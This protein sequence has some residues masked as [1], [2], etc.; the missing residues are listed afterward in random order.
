M[1]RVKNL[2]GK[3]YGRLVVIERCGIAHGRY[4]WSCLCDCG[5]FTTVNGS[6]LKQN[7]KG[8]TS[9][10]CLR[11]EL[12]TTHGMSKTR[13]Y[14]IWVDMRRRCTNP[15]NIVFSNYG[16][17]GISYDPRWEEFENFWEDMQNGYQDNLTL[18]RINPSGNY[19]KNNCK[20]DTMGNQA[21]N[22]K[23]YSN[24]KTGVDGTYFSTNR[25]VPCLKAHITKKDGKRITRSFSLSKYSVEE[26]LLLAKEWRE[27]QKQL[28]EY[29]E[30]HGIKTT[31]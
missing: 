7:N 26:A 5:T 29:G 12:Q 19:E 2:I 1:G 9:C 18:E 4:M 21:K 3:R 23:I 30:F 27:T 28:H 8:T 6:N 16:G 17:A 20:W 24:N 22:K 11:K 13:P 10:G 14:H 31:T 15:S 25:G